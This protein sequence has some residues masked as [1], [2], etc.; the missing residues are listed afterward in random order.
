MGTYSV[1]HNPIGLAF[2]GAN[3]WVA[4]NADGTVSKLRASDGT[5]LGTFSAP[6]SPYGVAFDGVNIWVTGTYVVEL[7]DSD[8]AQLGLFDVGSPTSTGVAFDGAN[9]WVA[10]A[11]EN[12]VNK[13]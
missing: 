11:F 3:I 2:D 7:R 5:T 6:G 13:M 12:S 8:G 9:I 10:V 4:N 1:G